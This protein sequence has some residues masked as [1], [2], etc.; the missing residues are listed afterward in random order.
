MSYREDFEWGEFEGQFNSINQNYKELFLRE[1]VE[2]NIYE[3][4]VEV[5]EGDIVVD[6]GASVGIFTE[7]IMSKNPKHVYCLEPYGPHFEVL[8][9]NMSI[10]PNVTCINLGISSTPGVN[11]LDNGLD[12]VIPADCVTFNQFVK[13]LNIESIDFLKLDCEGGEYDIITSDTYQDI[14]QVTKHISGEWH[15]SN[16]NLK[17]KF[18]HFRQAVL[19]NIPDAKIFAIDGVDIK[20]S[21]Y[22]QEFIEHYDEIH[23]YIDNKW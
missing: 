13:M 1:L 18:C 15:L 23:L 12:S 4:F 11:Q 10:Y 2:R 21:L 14:C 6:V 8:K 20:W 5:K 9:R 3:K 7:L 16:Q 22:N 19:K 17:A